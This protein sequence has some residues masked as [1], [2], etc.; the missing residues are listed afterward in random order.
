[1]RPVIA[2]FVTLLW[3]AA[4]PGQAEAKWSAI[5]V[6][7]SDASSRQGIDDALRTSQTLRENGGDVVVLLEDPEVKSL[8]RSLADLRG[9]SQLVLYYSGSSSE[10]RFELGPQG[11]SVDQLVSVISQTGASEVLLLVETCGTNQQVGRFSPQDLQVPTGM[12]LRI[13]TSPVSETECLPGQRL[14]DRLLHTS[15]STEGRDLLT[16]LVGLPTQGTVS[17]V[18]LQPPTVSDTSA[19]LVDFLPEDT[20]LINASRPDRA[21]PESAQDADPFVEVLLPATQPSF[22]LWRNDAEILLASLP[23][24]RDV[25]R[26][27][28]TGRPQPSIIIGSI[29]G[30]TDSDESLALS[31][32]PTDVWK[33]LKASDFDRFI[34]LLE[35]GAFD[36]PD[37]PPPGRTRGTYLAWAI[38]TELT[39]MNCRPNGIDGA[40]GDGSR[41]AADLFVDLVPNPDAVGADRETKPLFR[42]VL[43]H[44][45]KECAAAPRRVS[46]PTTQRPAPTPSQ[47]EPARPATTNSTGGFGQGLRGLGG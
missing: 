11:V 17:S 9:A 39:R 35:A 20:I 31:Y 19:R 4:L 13:V 2:L 34:E 3:I 7:Q 24:T 18:A 16:R 29:Q 43:R 1:M 27:Q 47:P 6:G 21:S 40:W 8:Q 38:Q 45:E 26:P 42:L 10:G 36:P 37:G 5:V 44:H 14:T 32:D 46:Q 33:A 15:G 41:R 28:G 23:S 25:T 12:Q 22:T 30:I